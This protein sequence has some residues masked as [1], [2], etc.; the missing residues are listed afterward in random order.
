MSPSRRAIALAAILVATFA[1][2]LT[3]TVLTIALRPVAT[4]MHATI[5]D[6]AW[7]TIAPA[8]FSGLLTPAFGKLADRLGRRLVFRFGL[9]L[10]LAGTIGSAVAPT[11]F[12][13]IASRVLTGI[14][15]AASMP[16]G[17]ALA[18]SLY[19]ADERTVPMGYWTSVTAFAP[20]I[21]VLLGGSVIEH[22][23]WRWLFVGQIPFALGSLAVA[24][25]AV[26][27]SEGSDEGRFDHMGAVLLGAS[28]FLLT[29]AANRANAW[30]FTSLP[31]ASA[32]LV[33]G[34][35]LAGVVYVERRVDNPVV[36]IRALSEPVV[37]FALAGRS[38]MYAVHMGSFVLLPLYLL[39]VGGRTPSEIAWMLLPRPVAMG[40]AAPIATRLVRSFGSSP[41]LVLG[42]S[43]M[44]V[45]IASLAFIEPSDDALALL[46]GLVGMGLGL[47][48]S[49]TVTA[50][51]IAGRT[52]EEDLGSASAML[53]IATALSGSLGSAA[54]LA[55]ATRPNVEPARAYQESFMACAVVCV[56]ALITALA[57]VRARSLELA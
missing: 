25:V 29:L 39:D 18:T 1:N 30:G 56:L 2:Y 9:V 15:S 11:L 20:A 8:L 46:P 3:I 48:L 21:G 44:L 24:F 19:A 6:V 42:V 55:F 16:S 50:S 22:L 13:L 14:G 49:Q 35:A 12:W 5:D 43:A 52:A 53:A 57:Q 51:E 28:F 7:V 4:E 23:S 54:L 33:A 17:I 32:A 26:P 38:L 10:F 47:G 34:L 31:V 37:R 36:P 45:G 41:V 40:F 27:E